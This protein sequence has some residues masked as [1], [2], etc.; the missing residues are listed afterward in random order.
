MRFSK[1]GV[2][3]EWRIARKYPIAKR[4]IGRSI[5]NALMLGIVNRMCG[6]TRK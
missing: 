1:R 6:N 5:V 2:Y 4:N 3:T